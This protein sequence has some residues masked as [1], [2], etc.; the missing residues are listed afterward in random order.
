[1]ERIIP[2]I[3]AHTHHFISDDEHICFHTYRH[4]I[5]PW[6]V[7]KTLNQDQINH[8][9]YNPPPYL[10]EVGIDR[11]KDID[12]KIQYTLF[13]QYLSL[14]QELSL[15]M[16]VHSVGAHSD[17]VSALK[18]FPRSKVLI[19]GFEGNCQEAEMLLKHNCFLSFGAAL[20]QKEKCQ[21]S[22]KVVPQDRLFFETDD[23]QIVLIDLI[24]QKASSILNIELDSLKQMIY[25]N[26][27]AFF[28]EKNDW[29]KMD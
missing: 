27:L 26:A 10:G 1:M 29:K 28:G 23:Q 2:F 20:L 11:S 16:I 3:D 6:L 24:Y 21:Q 5:H 7:K 8:I 17:I 22:I 4:G 25:A 9:R 13:C 12:P 14:A 19:H 18:Q 15:P